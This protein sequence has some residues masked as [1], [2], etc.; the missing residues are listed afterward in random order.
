[1][2]ALLDDPDNINYVLEALY[3]DKA[4][5]VAT[6]LSEGSKLGVF[7]H[8]VSAMP[9]LLY[10]QKELIEQFPQGFVSENAIFISVPYYKEVGAV[11]DE[12]GFYINNT[13]ISGLVLVKA[14]IDL[15]SYQFSVSFKAEEQ[16]KIIV[17]TQRKA[18]ER[19]A[20]SLFLDMGL[21][22]MEIRKFPFVSHS[23]LLE[24]IKPLRLLQEE[25]IEELGVKNDY[26]VECLFKSKEL[27]NMEHPF[28][29][30]MQAIHDRKL[31]E[32]KIPLSS[33]EYYDSLGS[34]DP[35][36]KKLAL[37]AVINIGS[38]IVNKTESLQDFLEEAQIK[39][40]PFLDIMKAPELTYVL[41]ELHTKLTKKYVGNKN[42]NK[43][44]VI[45]SSNYINN[46]DESIAFI[47]EIVGHTDETGRSIAINIFTNFYMINNDGFIKDL[48]KENTKLQAKLGIKK[49]ESEPAE[50]EFD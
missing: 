38:K 16:D 24:I 11:K 37:D 18:T 6:M 45:S 50:E 40:L 21:N 43:S 30:L 39:W 1:M 15:L 7:S 44:S 8:I 46:S 29:K 35:N 28:Y 9:I 27:Y 25:R 26:L 32:K 14:I 48:E 19:T 47:Q 34:Y 23:K 13:N 36:K 17:W 49:R 41:S 22:D 5:L 4:A 12:E 33:D 31:K 10:D 2:D 3:N 42:T 20:L